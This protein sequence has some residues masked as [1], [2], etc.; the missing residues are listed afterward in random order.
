M[1]IELAGVDAAAYP[2]QYISDHEVLLSFNSD[3]HAAVFRD[4][5]HGAWSDFQEYM[6]GNPPVW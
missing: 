1:E 6:E 5:L 3:E 4:W 2:I